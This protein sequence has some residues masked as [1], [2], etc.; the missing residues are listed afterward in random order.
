MH[1]LLDDI[2]DGRKATNDF[3][4][5]AVEGQHSSDREQRAEAAERQLTKVK[6]LHYMKDR[7]G[8]EM[9]AIVTGVEE[10][11]LFVQGID[12]PAE[13]LIHITSLQD[14]Y[15]IFD[16]ATHTLCGRRSDS[17]FRLGDY[18]RVAVARVDH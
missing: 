17:V 7:I 4:Q 11:G 10:Y 16:R 12:I 8:E 2:F 18:V 9:E 14:D 13:G 3:D 6:L 15:Y 5:L 1:R